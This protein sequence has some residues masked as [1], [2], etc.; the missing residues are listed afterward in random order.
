MHAY[1]VSFFAFPKTFTIFVI[2]FPENIKE[3]VNQ[4]PVIN[5]PSLFLCFE[6][7]LHSMCFVNQRKSYSIILAL[8]NFFYKEP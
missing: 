5:A 3:N 1:F 8:I 7:T 2:K 4:I 6:M